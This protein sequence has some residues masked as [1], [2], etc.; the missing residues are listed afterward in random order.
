M[1]KAISP[2]IL[3]LSG[4]LAMGSAHANIIVNGDFETGVFGP[5]LIT[6]NMFLIG[7][8]GGDFW[9]GG[10]STAQNGTRAVAF[11]ADDT[12][13]NGTIS[14]SFA[15]VVGET[16]A[17][18]YDFGATQ[19]AT[20]QITAS[21]LGTSGALY[22]QLVSD[23]NPLQALTTF[24][25]AFIADGNLATL[26]FTDFTG[27]F[28]VS[29]DGILDNVS[30]LGAIPIPEPENYALMLAGLGLLGFTVL[31]RRRAPPSAANQAL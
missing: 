15:T 25:F 8:A 20:Q 19:N 10:G 23:S 18:Q 21:V 3:A 28:T 16:Y 5:W 17:V 2:A 31:R 22:S 7:T 11:N 13:P 9:F 4:V 26:R 29:E 12:V 6:G 27:N 24:S 14:Q 1:T 30:V